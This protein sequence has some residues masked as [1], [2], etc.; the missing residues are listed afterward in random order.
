MWAWAQ[1]AY[2]IPF[3]KYSTFIPLTILKKRKKRKTF[4]ASLTTVLLLLKAKQKKPTYIIKK[5][6]KTKTPY[7]LSQKWQKCFGAL[8]RWF[9]R[10]VYAEIYCKSVM[11]T[12]FPHLHASEQWKRGSVIGCRHTHSPRCPAWSEPPPLVAPE[13]CAADLVGSDGYT[14]RTGNKRVINTSSKRCSMMS[15]R[16]FS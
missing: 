13:Q 8:V 4:N 5:M 1:R 3:T 7:N 10:R 11:K 12:L 14:A 9:S 15:I 2:F 6:V 16:A